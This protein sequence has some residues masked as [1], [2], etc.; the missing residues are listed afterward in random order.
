[1]TRRGERLDATSSQQQG[2]AQPDEAQSRLRVLGQAQLV[3]VSA[4][5]QALEIDVGGAGTAVAE[6]GDFGIGEELG[7]HPRLLGALPRKNESNLTHPA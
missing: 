3:F 2:K 7:P 6:L 4:D 1:V 5:E